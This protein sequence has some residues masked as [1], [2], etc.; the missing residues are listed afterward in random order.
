ML[1]QILAV[2]LC[3]MGLFSC[4]PRS[5][6]CYDIDFTQWYRDVH[7]FGLNIKPTF[8][9][10]QFYL[11]PIV[12]LHYFSGDIDSSYSLGAEVGYDFE[13]VTIRAGYKDVNDEFVDNDAFY[14]GAAIR[15]D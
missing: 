9:E 10:Q 6:F 8:R 12:G 5:G 11:A 2:I 15:F 4:K 14:V 13:R 7:S 1:S 3:N